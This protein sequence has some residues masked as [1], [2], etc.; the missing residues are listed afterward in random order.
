MNVWGFSLVLVDLAKGNLSPAANPFF[1][2]PRGR[3]TPFMSIFEG[4]QR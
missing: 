4:D 3:T 1:G 2:Q